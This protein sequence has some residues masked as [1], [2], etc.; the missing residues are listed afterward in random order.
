[1]SLAGRIVS[2]SEISHERR[3]TMYRLMT[4]HYEHVRREEFDSDLDEKEWVLDIEEPATGKLC[5]FSTQML[6]EAEVDGQTV[7]A[8]YSGD[9]IVDPAYR[10]RNPLAGL[11]GNL[12]LQ[13][14]DQFEGQMLYWFLISKGYKTYRF[15]PVFF[16]EFHPRF[17]RPMPAEYSRLIHAFGRRKFGSGYDANRQIVAARAEGCRLRPGVADLTPERMT[18]SHVAFFAA[19]NP[20]HSTGDELC[21]L[22]PLTREN[23]TR[24]AWRVIRETESIVQ[25]VLTSPALHR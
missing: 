14:I 19:R 9:T 12:A 24:A 10:H 25:G 5:G 8:L 2:V 6:L 1:M 7:R 15:L 17:D 11:W 21:C 4:R 13:L 23:Y 20:N 22:A 16:R 3:E 18:D